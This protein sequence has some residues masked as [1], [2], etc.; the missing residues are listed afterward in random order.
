[1]PSVEAPNYAPSIN[2]EE[3]VDHMTLASGETPKEDGSY[4]IHPNVNQLTFSEIV[5][6]ISFVQFWK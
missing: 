2:I 4:S 5:C 3:T 1:M 6:Y